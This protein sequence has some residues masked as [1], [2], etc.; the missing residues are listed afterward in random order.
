[1]NFLEK[2]LQ[3]CVQKQQKNTKNNSNPGFVSK[4]PEK[5]IQEEKD[6]LEKYRDMLT[7]VVERLK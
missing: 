5:K 3:N 7:K 4:A 1:M 2:N 6:K